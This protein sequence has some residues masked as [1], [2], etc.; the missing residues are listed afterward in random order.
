MYVLKSII[1]SLF[2]L[3]CFSF[4]AKSVS[5]QNSINGIVFDTNRNPVSEITVEL[6]DEFERLIRSTKTKGSGLYFFQSLPA[7]TYYVQVRVGGTG[8]QQEKERI[9]LGVSN[10]VAATSSGSRTTGSESRQVNITLKTDDR[11]RD[12]TPINNT[13]VF[14]QN[15]PEDA[16]RFYKQALEDLGNNNEKEALQ[17]LNKAIQIFP[18]YFNAL[19]R[20][21]NLYLNQNQYT[22]AEDVF[23]KAIAVNAK[24]FGSYFGLAV[25]QNMLKKKIEAIANLQKANELDASSITVH[26]LLGIIQRELKQFN[27]SE[28]SLLKAKKL[29]DNQVPDVHWNLALLYYYNFQNYELA[30]QELKLYLKSIPKNQRTNRKEEIKQVNDLIDKLSDKAKQASQ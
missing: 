14:A 29:S 11:N 10:R 8:Y 7:G 27:E 22:E 13:V 9:E 16:E 15:V 17:K 28:Q 19:E 4:T 1:C 5:A 18:D 3:V 23:K 2:I 26:L 12:R 30:I 24:G 20:L 25:A 21:G 6:L